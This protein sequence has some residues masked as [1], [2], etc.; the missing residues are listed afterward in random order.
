MD[1]ARFTMIDEEFKCSNC[2]KMVNPLGYSARDHCPYCLCSIHVDNNPGDRMCSCKGLLVPINIEKGKKDS[3]KIVYK[4]SKCNMI[5]RNISA[6]DDDMDKIIDIMSKV[7][8]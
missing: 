6:R 7:E 8:I 3:F 1:K 4:C 5:K 2:G